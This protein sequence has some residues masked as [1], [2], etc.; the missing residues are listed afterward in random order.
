MS[1]VEK[2]KELFND[3]YLMGPNSLRLLDEM[4]EKHPISI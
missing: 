2:Y 1:K 4:L 3:K